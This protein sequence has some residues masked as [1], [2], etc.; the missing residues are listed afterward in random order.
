[1]EEN[2]HPRYPWEW[3]ERERLREL[4]RCQCGL[5]PRGEALVAGVDEVGRGP[6]AGPVVACAVV[7]DFPPF[8]PGLND[9]K[10]VPVKLREKICDAVKG[11][12]LSWAVG[13]AAVEEI[14]RLNIL[15]ASLLAMKRAL[16]G[17]A[18]KPGLV[19]VDGN[20]AVPGISL[21]QKTVVKGDARV[22]SIAAASVVAKVFRDDLMDRLDGEFPGYGFSS[23]KGYGT[24]AHLA[25]LRSLG[26]SPAHRQSFAPVRSLDPAARQ[27]TLA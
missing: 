3:E 8:L 18:V 7:F 22:F 6:L 13:I 1:M 16:E 27:L 11:S 19:L 5:L 4:Y 24:A 15:A 9:S 17:L 25:A 14:D 21:P 12:A 2:T 10:K 23:H 20:K 26:P